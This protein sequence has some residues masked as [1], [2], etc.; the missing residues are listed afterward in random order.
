MKSTH[1]Q[2]AS[3]IR[4]EL[5]IVFPDIKFSVR[6]ESFAGG[7]SV[8]VSYQDG[9]PVKEVEKFV[10]KYQYGHFNG[11]EDLYE[12]T[13]DRNDI[14]QVK[15]TRVQREVSEA[16]REMVKAEL[17]K[18]YGMKEWSDKEA[19]RVSGRWTHNLL[20]GNMVDRTFFKP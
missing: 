13:N 18:S 14:P 16:N 2:A 12:H 19:K 7:N 9:P 5:K 15:Y 1:A 10:D 4:A 8:E 17:M 11:M 6:S 3:A 20:W